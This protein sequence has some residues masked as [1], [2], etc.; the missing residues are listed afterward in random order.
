MRELETERLILRDW[1]LSDLD[2]YY[3]I[4]SSPNIRIPDAPTKTKDNCLSIL[5]YLIKVGNNYALVLKETGKVIGSV[6]LNEDGDGN[7]NARNV[8]FILN[9]KYWNRGLMTEALKEIIKNAHEITPILSCGH[10]ES[11]KKSEH[12]IKKLGF[13]YIKTFHLPTHDF[14]YYTLNLNDIDSSRA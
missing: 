9:E 8:G 11:N 12:I 7:E 4:M 1:K 14:I 13:N 3:D 5:Q 2:D 6:G 10:A